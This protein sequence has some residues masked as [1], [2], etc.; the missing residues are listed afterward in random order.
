M[1]HFHPLESNEKKTI[2]IFEFGLVIV[3]MESTAFSPFKR[4]FLIQF[5]LISQKIEPMKRG[6]KRV[7]VSMSWCA[8]LLLIEGLAIWILIKSVSLPLTLSDVCLVPTHCP[9]LERSWRPLRDLRAAGH[10]RRRHTRQGSGERLRGG[11]DGR[12]E[13]KLFE[14]DDWGRG[15]EGRSSSHV[16]LFSLHVVW[17]KFGLFLG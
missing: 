8:L 17:V 1:T 7:S 10:A 16:L 2:I 4:A 11:G 9:P 13:W 15:R 12:W 14:G 5:Y 6:T 3:S